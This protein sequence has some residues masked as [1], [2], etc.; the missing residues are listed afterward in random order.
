MISDVNILNRDT[1]IVSETDANG[2]IVYVNDD[3]CKVSK[4]SKSE[5]IGKPH[6]I[7]R[8]FDMPKTAF[9]ELWAVIKEG[10]VWKGVVKNKTRD[11]NFYWV[12][13]TISFTHC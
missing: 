6:N 8:H 5:L 13:A 9:K 11:G 10:K 7:V 4:F 12:H 3:F 1:I 2:R